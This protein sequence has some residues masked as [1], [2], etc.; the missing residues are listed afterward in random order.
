VAVCVTQIEYWA[1]EDLRGAPDQGGDYQHRGLSAR[2]DT[3][4]R[5]IVAEARAMGGTAGG[6]DA[7]WVHDRAVTEC[8]ALIAADPEP[9]GF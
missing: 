6:V 7:A 8:T 2:I 4:L 9:A 5:A 3:A 1:G